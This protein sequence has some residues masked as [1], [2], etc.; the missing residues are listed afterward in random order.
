[1]SRKEEFSFEKALEELELT[2]QRL[3]EGDLT[4][5]ESIALYEMGV[6]LA[7]QCEDALDKA[8]IRVEELTAVSSQ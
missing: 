8:Q 1:M 7:R 2:V 6:Q 5:D 3:E 4:L